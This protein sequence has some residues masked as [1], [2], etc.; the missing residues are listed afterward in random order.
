MQP[1]TALLCICGYRF[2]HVAGKRAPRSINAGVANAPT[3]AERLLWEAREALVAAAGLPQIEGA[4]PPLY[5]GPVPTTAAIPHHPASRT[6]W[7]VPIATLPAEPAQTSPVTKVRHSTVRTV[8][9]TAPPSA[10]ATPG[11]HPG[12]RTPVDSPEAEVAAPPP[13]R[14]PQSTSEATAHP[15]EPANNGDA[16]S[17]THYRPGPGQ[18]TACPNCTA[19]VQLGTNRCRCG[20]VLPDED[21]DMPTLAL[22]PSELAAIFRGDG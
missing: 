17:E 7:P 21:S 2:P 15:A 4:P 20:F 19:A 12:T 9:T 8:S 22:G 10:P 3:D 5:S 6:R 16:A 18:T 1:S 14:Q 13:A 11:A